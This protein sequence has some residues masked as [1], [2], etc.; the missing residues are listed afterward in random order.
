MART[1]VGAITI[2]DIQDGIHPLSV[3]LSNQSHTF[4]ADNEGTVTTLEKNKFMCEINAYVGGTRVIYDPAA[5]PAND[6]YKI[7]AITVVPDTWVTSTAVVTD[8]LQISMLTVPTGNV[9]TTCQISIPIL[10]KNSLGNTTQIDMVISLAK[11]IEGAGGQAVYIQPDRQTFQFDEFGVTTDGTIT[12]AVSAAG[13]VGSLTAEKSINGGVWSALTVGAGADQAASV[14]LDGLGDD[15]VITITAAN[16]DDSHS[17]GIKVVGAT[18]GSDVIN[19]IR[20]Q[21]GSTGPAALIV[22]ITSDIGGFVFKNNAGAEKTLTVAVWDAAT[23]N[24]ITPT[25]FQWKKNGVNVGLNQDSF[26]VNA[27]DVTDNG[28]EEYSCEVTY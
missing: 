9:V 14:D 16:F 3:V 26:A 23:G 13:L 17:L 22:S 27:T 25:S 8:Q 18:G 19:I 28:S 1:A 10:I 15:D 24:L 11:A 4:A 7:G 12:L 5:T 20:I 2:M 6:T 21:D